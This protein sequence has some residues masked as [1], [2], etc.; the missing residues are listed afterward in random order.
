MANAYDVQRGK[1][2]QI[3]E[4]MD[5]DTRPKPRSTTTSTTM[6]MKSSRGLEG[7]GFSKAEHR[8]I[9]RSADG[10]TPK[11]DLKSMREQE[12]EKRRQRRSFG[13]GYGD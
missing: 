5:D 11:T 2:K 4:L 7:H 10:G 6:P 1:K 8:A 13:V 12:D 3:A 9:M